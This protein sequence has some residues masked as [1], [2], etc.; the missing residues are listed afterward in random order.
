MQ[1][2]AGEL[3]GGLES[4]RLQTER[5]YGKGKI[6][7]GG[8][9]SIKKANE[10]YP[11]YD[12]TAKLLNG[13]GVAEDFKSAAPVRYTHRTTP[14]WDIYFVS[15]RTNEPIKGDC[16]F[17]TAKASPELWDPLTGKIR[18]LPE[19]SSTDGRTTVPLQFDAFQ[20]FFIVFAKGTSGASS[21]RKNFPEKTE[22]AS[23][24]GPWDVSF[25][26]KWGGP[27]KVRFDS[28]KDWTLRPEEGIKYYSGIAVYR[29]HFDLPKAGA[30]DKNNRLYLDL[31]EVKNLARVWLNGQDM[32]VVWTA[33]W[34]VDFTEAVK[35]Q[36]NT[37]EIEVANLWPNRLIGDEK[38]PDDGIK[39]GQWPDWL[40]KEKGK[41]TCQTFLILN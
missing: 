7:W 3:W 2:I 34:R 17:R 22:I 24:N 37:L 38:L 28:L 4:P 9:L 14:D 8:D 5:I 35:Q 29:Q 26:S 13:M 39:D 40:I 6:I 23:L 41:K 32:G 25:D 11:S 19:F 10:L 20:S 18:K 15:N 36:G 33:P 1:S 16:I 27:E 21:E 31:G 30:T 12:L